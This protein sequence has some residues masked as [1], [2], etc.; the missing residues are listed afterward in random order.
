MLELLTSLLPVMLFWTLVSTYLGGWPVDLRGGS[1]L[2]QI[3]GLV[4]TF[5]LWVVAWK[6]LH[7]VF[8]GFGPVLGGL[9]ITTFIAAF[10]FP[11]VAWL[12]FKMVGV[13]VARS[14]GHAH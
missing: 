10:L 6:L 5:V 4:L 9:V 8:V 1:G 12:G 11:F 14:H 13:T 3:L 7:A 2:T